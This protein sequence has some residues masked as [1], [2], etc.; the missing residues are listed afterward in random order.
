VPPKLTNPQFIYN[1]Q[2]N[3][4]LPQ[5]ERYRINLLLKI[6]NPPENRDEEEQKEQK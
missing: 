2:H 5:D 4:Y 3:I 1:A 6:D